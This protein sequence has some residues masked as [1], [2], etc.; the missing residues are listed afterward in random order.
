MEI[1]SLDGTI[2]SFFDKV[3]PN[4]QQCDDLASSLVR[5]PVVPVSIQGSFSYTVSTQRDKD[6]KIV[7]FRVSHSALDVDI[8]QLAQRIHGD[9]V[10]STRYYGEIGNGPT[11]PVKVYVIEKLPGVTFIDIM[12][13]SERTSCPM[14]M[15]RMR[16]I[17][18][19]S[20]YKY[21]GPAILS[22]L[23]SNSLS[24]FFAATWLHPRMYRRQSG[25]KI[26]R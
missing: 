6:Q 3:S 5:G 21:K 18:D 19:I 11:A 15:P 12:L 1:Y 14:P 17:E 23:S 9:I 7:Q 16:M 24:R 20:R 2:A 4:R 13:A 26:N 8:I 25:K 10:P 22:L